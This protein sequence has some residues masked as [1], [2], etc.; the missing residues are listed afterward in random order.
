MKKIETFQTFCSPVLSFLYMWVIMFFWIHSISMVNLTNRRQ[1]SNLPKP[2][3]SSLSLWMQWAGWLP[4]VRA[5]CPASLSSGG[6]VLL[7]GGPRT[8][9]CCVRKVT[10]LVELGALGNSK[11]GMV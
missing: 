2:L 6:A 5:S 10:R 7:Q 8:K 3:A 4:C 1:I 11:G 9:P